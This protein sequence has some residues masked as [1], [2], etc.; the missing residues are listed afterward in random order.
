[1][2]VANKINKLI[3]Q[4]ICEICKK[5]VAPDCISLLLSH[6]YHRG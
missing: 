5:M 2:H 4:N 3:S 6:T 1:M